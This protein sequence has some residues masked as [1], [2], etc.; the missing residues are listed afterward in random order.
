MRTSRRGLLLAVVVA[1]ARAFGAGVRTHMDRIDR[2]T[3]LF[4][5]RWACP[6]IAE[7]H[8]SDGAKFVTLVGRLGSNPAAMRTTLD[9][10]LDLGWI[11]RNPGYGHPMRPEYLLTSHGERIAPAC[12]K[13]DEALDSPEVKDVALRKWSMPVLYVVGD[14]PTRFSEVT[15]SL[16]GATD[17]AVSLSLKSLADAAIVERS[18]V[19]GPPLGTA[20]A[21]T[22]AGGILLPILDRI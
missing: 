8:R 22:R 7:L 1:L 2:L 3:A 11:R 17:R 21:A 15:R 10:L 4:R 19:T 12:A 14:G 18:L 6:V 13:L 5:R 20:Y 9:E 16:E